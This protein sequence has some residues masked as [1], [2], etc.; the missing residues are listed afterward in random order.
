MGMLVGSLLVPYITTASTTWICLLTLLSIHLYTNYCAVRAVCLPSLNCQRANLVFSHYFSHHLTLE[1]GEKSTSN[2]EKHQFLA[3]REVF[4]HERIFE[5]PSVLRHDGIILGYCRIGVLMSELLA[6][7]QKSSSHRTSVSALVD[8]YKDVPY[9]LHLTSATR[10]VLVALKEHSQSVY[11]QA[12][13]HA[14]TI[15]EAFSRGVN[16]DA[17]FLQDRAESVER[18]WE[19]IRDGLG[20]AGWDVDDVA[21]LTVGRGRVRIGRGLGGRSEEGKKVV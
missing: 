16:V 9:V 19:G 8:T 18:V 20:K 3:P 10:T 21:I 7:F 1:E 5:N 14:F 2:R 17:G 12:W 6:A 13:Y 15:V 11:L 4:I